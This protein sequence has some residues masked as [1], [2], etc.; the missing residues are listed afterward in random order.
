MARSLFREVTADELIE[1]SRV[2]LN[3]PYNFA[4]PPYP[5]IHWELVDLLHHSRFPFA[6]HDAC[7]K[8][9]FQAI[10]LENFYRLIEPDTVAEPGHLSVLTVAK[11]VAY[12]LEVAEATAEGMASGQRTPRGEQIL[13]EIN[14]LQHACMQAYTELSPWRQFYVAVRHPVVRYAVNNALMNRWGAESFP[15]GAPGKTA[16]A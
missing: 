16:S 10:S 8:W 2:R 14:R 5:A 9:G 6:R 1:V 13:E 15:A 7:D 4:E 11:V 3:H 12:A